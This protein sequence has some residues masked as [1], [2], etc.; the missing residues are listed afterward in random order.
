MKPERDIQ[1]F[2]R[3]AAAGID[4]GTDEKVLAR[5]LAAHEAIDPNDS[6]VRRSNMRSTI[7]RIP[8]VRV[9]AVALICITIAVV[10]AV[11]VDCVRYYYLGKDDTGHHRFDSTDGQ[12][13]VTMNDAP[14]MDP[15]QARRDIEEMAFLSK[16][17]LRELVKV[18]RI[19]VNGQMERKMLVYRYRLADGRIQEIGEIPPENTGPG[20][21]TGPQHSELMRLKDAGP[22]EDRGAYDEDILGRTFAFTRQRYVLSDGTE[23]IWAAGTPK[24]SP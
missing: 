20:T 6:A 8:A 3:K 23:V 13:M 21:L 14:G 7:M 12:N 18:V 17:G 5:I 9:I 22:G 16:Q 4:A 10:T 1:Q 2:F 19:D 15:E 24:N 11:G